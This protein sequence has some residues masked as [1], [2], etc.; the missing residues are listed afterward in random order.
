[1]TGLRYDVLGIGNAIVDV[2]ARAEDDF[3]VAQGM[4][5][6]TMALIDE[7]RA[8]AIYAAMGP[9]TESSGGSAAN[10]I[11]GVAS[12]GARAAFVGKVKEDELGRAFVHDIRAAGV[13]FDTRPATTGPSTARCYI[14]V[15]P[16]GERTMNT[17]LGAAQ[18]LRPADIDEGQVA[19]AAVTYLEGYL[20]DPPRAKEAFVKAASIAHKAG[21]HVAL[22]LSDAFCVDRYRA[23]FLDLIRKGVIDI[24]F[25]N[26]R[27]LHSL[28]ETADFDIAVKALRGEAKLAVVTRSEKGCVVVSREAVTA[29]PA[30][31]VEQ[32]AD[33]TGAGDL[34]AAG[35]LAGLAR[36]KDHRTSARLGGIAAA[37]VI[38]H[39][40]ARPAVSLKTR[41]AE[42]GVAL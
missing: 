35:F 18:D 30:E 10:T 22:T 39:V 28:Y 42:N 26:E 38:Q 25:A 41:A 19:S 36:G 34:F 1:M 20:W 6:G 13:A 2:I 4:H 37:E 3:L 12:F 23:E 32:V 24:V 29:V 7:A 11:V 16:D 17:F 27:E 21:R 33:V 15:T 9:A 31:P 40:G 14:M 5:K 8:Q